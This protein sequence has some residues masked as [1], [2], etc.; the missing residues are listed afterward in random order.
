DAAAV[1]DNTADQI[2][3]FSITVAGLLDGANERLK[4]NADNTIELNADFSASDISVGGIAGLD[5]DYTQAT[6]VL[7]ISLNAGGDFTAAQVQ[8]VIAALEY[9]N[10]LER[11]A[12][13]GARTFTISI[14]DS[15]GNQADAVASITTNNPGPRMDLDTASDGSGY[16][17]LENDASTA[18]RVFGTP[19]V[20]AFNAGTGIKDILGSL[21]RFDIIVSGVNKA[22]GGEY[23]D[24]S[25]NRLYLHEDGSHNDIN[26]GGV[27]GVRI[28]FTAATDTL[29]IEPTLATR[30]FTAD[31]VRKMLRAIQYGDESGN[32]ASSG[33]RTFRVELTDTLAADKTATSIIKMETVAP[34]IDLDDSEAGSGYA[35]ALK[36]A[37]AG[38]NLGLNISVTDQVTDTISS[39]QITISGTS[40]DRA[41]ESIDLNGTDSIELDADNSASQRT[42]G[43]VANVD[44]SFT[45]ATG[46][47]SFSLHSGADFNAA[48]A[49]AILRA[50]SFEN[51]LGSNATDG[52]RDFTVSLTDHAGNTGQAVSSITLDNTAPELDLDGRTLS[53]NY[54]LVVADSSAG[55]SLQ[56]TAGVTDPVTDRIRGFVIEITGETADAASESIDLNGVD[57]IAL[58]ADNSAT[59]RTIGGVADVDVS[60]SIAARVLNFSRHDGEDFSAAQVQAILRAIEYQ[61]ALG[62]GA[63]DGSRLFDITLTDHLG[64]ANTARADI[65]LDNTAPTLDINGA[66]SGNDR[67]QRSNDL[68][69]GLALVDSALTL[70]D[71]NDAFSGIQFIISGESA[72]A[73]QEFLDFGATRMALG[74]DGAANNRSINGVSGV[75]LNY[76]AASRTLSLSLASGNDFSAAQ[77]RAILQSASFRNALGSDA[78]DGQ[79]DIAIKLTDQAG[80]VST[81]SSGILLDT[82]APTLDLNGNEQGTGRTLAAADTSSGI[83]LAPAAGITDLSTDQISSLSIRLSGTDSDAA[84]E[85]IRFAGGASVTLSGDS[86]QRNLRIGTINGISL[87]FEQATRTLDIRL[88]NGGNLSAEQAQS[89][90]RGAEYLNT[91][92]SD[93]TDGERLFTVRATDH[94][95]NQGAAELSLTLD[96]TAPD[97]GLR[98]TGISEDSGEQGDFL[99]NDADGISVIGEVTRLLAADERLEYSRDGGVSWAEIT[100]AINGTDLNLNDPDFDESGTVSFRFLDA[101]NNAGP[102]FSQTITID[103]QA[104]VAP[105]T[106]SIDTGQSSSRPSF[107]GLGGQ[108]GDRIEL[109]ITP[110]TGSGDVIEL[111]GTVPASGP[112]SLI[113]SADLPSGSYT[114]VS[115]YVDPAGN[116]SG[117]SPALSFTIGAA[118][119]GG[120]NTGRG[121]DANFGDA[122]GLGDNVND[123]TDEG[124]VLDALIETDEVS[125]IG[126]DLVDPLAPE[127]V[128]TTETLNETPVRN[129]AANAVPSLV[130]VDRV[131]V[132]AYT[133]F[134]AVDEDG[135][136]LTFDLEIDTDLGPEASLNEDGSFTLPAPSFEPTPIADVSLFALDEVIFSFD[137]GAG[138]LLQV[139]FGGGQPEGTV[140]QPAVEQEGEDDEQA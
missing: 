114:A 101:L 100:R 77:A 33:D 26:V 66:G 24:L 11:N 140:P 2:S 52:S 86:E 80:N 25:N 131:F 138:E 84:N 60:F 87:S 61:N 136:G 43:G 32:G 69:D 137:A 74:A 95:G 70:S 57:S 67:S 48:Q 99:T 83:S 130:I 112:W 129:Y 93:A 46:V 88:T 76:N 50:L 15:S 51:A 8:A 123:E 97:L 106:P 135:V 6:G 7:S 54:R 47:L 45:Q 36:D 34:A 56:D 117:S 42:I 44:V 128:E 71:S 79:R 98:I 124:S 120:G 14:T 111:S 64:N 119:S 139:A 107:S 59:Q 78:R 113:S 12:N 127:T 108:P 133:T 121:D 103:T 38:V 125:G 23:L 49:Q 58:D 110:T 30:D 1:T 62:T 28:T 37:S 41:S 22:A 73:S 89:I 29:S 5:F 90:L 116:S 31:E 132:D 75:N 134:E 19:S 4:L 21:T 96:N 122:D 18:V 82:T 109:R 40:S 105:G 10:A 55:V 35:L 94:T 16:F 85:R 63:T 115:R 104:P 20:E 17:L 27:P 126:S 81:R 68:S 3:G 118:A 102:E 72:N 9:S 39:F 92:G 91:L 13:D 53:D 65:T